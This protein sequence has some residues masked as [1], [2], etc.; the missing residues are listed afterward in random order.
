MGNKTLKRIA[1]IKKF[2]EILEDDKKLLLVLDEVGFGT[3]SLRHY[4]YSKIGKPVIYEKSKQTPHNLTFT[5]TISPN[6]VEFIQCFDKGGTKS[7]YF[8]YHFENLIETM[9][10][11]YPDKTIV[12]LQDNLA[13]H[14]SQ[15]IMKIMHTEKRLEMLLTPSNSP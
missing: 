11:K 3:A 12:L 4:A 15:Q 6:C 10:K 8:S 9:L 14:K 1:F 7:E 13:A 5:V 2:F